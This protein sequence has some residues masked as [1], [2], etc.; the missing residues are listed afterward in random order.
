MKNTLLPIATDLAVHFSRVRICQ[1][2]PLIGC[3]RAHMP[4]DTIK[5]LP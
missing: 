5:D 3:N 4:A 1:I 2:V